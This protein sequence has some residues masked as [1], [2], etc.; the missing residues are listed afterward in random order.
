MV[1]KQKIFNI[2]SMGIQWFR[3]QISRNPLVS[4]NWGFLFK[5]LTL[6]TPCMKNLGV[7][8]EVHITAES[9]R[10]PY[11]IIKNEL[12]FKKL[13][14]LIWCK[15]FQNRLIQSKVIKILRV[16]L[17]SVASVYP[18]VESREMPCT[19]LLQYYHIFLSWNIFIPS[20]NL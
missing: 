2:T 17:I 12:H 6:E 7:M 18:G 1:K 8:W 16:N 11:S 14:L 19:H 15:N 5:F 13:H 20:I 3:T 10:L 9:P 4:D